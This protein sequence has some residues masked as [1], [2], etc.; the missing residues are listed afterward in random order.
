[1]PM[2]VEIC[3]KCGCTEFDHEVNYHDDGCD[4]DCEQ[5]H[6]DRTRCSCGRCSEAERIDEPDELV[7]TCGCPEHVHSDD[8]CDRCGCTGWSEFG[9]AADHV[10]SEW[11]L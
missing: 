4:E 9:T 10:R 7:C 8:E 11:G 1:M 5:D 6:D 2:T 3:K